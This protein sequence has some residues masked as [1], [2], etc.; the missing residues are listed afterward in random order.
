MI[1]GIHRHGAGKGLDVGDEGLPAC[2]AGQELTAGHIGGVLPVFLPDPG[3]RTHHFHGHRVVRR[4][5]P[6]AVT[7]DR[8]RPGRGL[9]G[10]RADSARPSAEHCS[11]A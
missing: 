11:G 6:A 1:G 7:E 3:G 9:H 10:E 5:D 8:H 2:H 4:F